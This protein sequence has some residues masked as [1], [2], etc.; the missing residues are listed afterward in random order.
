MRQHTASKET[1][2]N[3]NNVYARLVTE[4][5]S[6]RYNLV[7]DGPTPAKGL[8]GTRV[9]MKIDLLTVAGYRPALFSLLHQIVPNTANILPTLRSTLQTLRYTPPGPHH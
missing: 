4:F 2:S 6:K 9:L 5:L 8:V 1:I 3:Y 7:T